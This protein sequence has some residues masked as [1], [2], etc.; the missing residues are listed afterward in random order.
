MPPRRS[1]PST[2][3]APTP[4]NPIA[5]HRLASVSFADPVVVAG[6]LVRAS[7]VARWRGALDAA[8]RLAEQ[9]L[10]TSASGPRTSAAHD[11][12]VEALEAIIG[13]A[14]RRAHPEAIASMTQRIDDFATATGS[15]AATALTLFIRWGG[16]DEAEDLS[17][18]RGSVERAEELLATYTDDYAVLTLRFMVAAWLLMVGEIDAAADHAD[19]ALAASGRSDPDASP[20]HVPLVLLPLIA[21]LVAAL[22]G[23]AV[24]AHDHVHRRALAWMRARSAVDPTAGL[25]LAYYRAL[26]AAILDDP[27]E[28]HD[29]LGGIPRTDPS[30]FVQTEAQAAE[31]LVGWA[32]VRLGDPDGLAVAFAALAAIERSPEHIL[33]SFLRTCVADACLALDDDRAMG[34][35]E[36]ADAE[37]RSRGERWWLAET[38]RLQALADRRFGDGRRADDLL[39]EAEALARRQ[40]ATLLV[41]R[42]AAQREAAS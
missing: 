18:V 30:G 7:D 38:M 3:T 35:L 11:A 29:L 26:A 9:A 17:T 28:V 33:R 6:A 19:L 31:L 15:E 5:H 21:G 1:W 34:L 36:T 24:A 27:Q 16:I 41:E 20:D 10:E 14:Y 2:A 23:D 8:E 40:G 25:A 22:R 37:A 39:A 13:V 42:L 32:Q 4:P 12:E